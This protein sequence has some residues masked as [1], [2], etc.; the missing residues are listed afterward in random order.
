[1]PYA[2]FY[3]PYCGKSERRSS[4]LVQLVAC[5]A[6]STTIS[7]YSSCYKFEENNYKCL[8]CVSCGLSGIKEEEKLKKKLK[9]SE[10]EKQ[11]NERLLSHCAQCRKKSTLYH[12]IFDRR[13]KKLTQSTSNATDANNQI[14]FCTKEHCFQFFREA[15]QNKKKKEQ[16]RLGKKKAKEQALRR[17]FLLKLVEAISKGYDVSE[18]IS[19]GEWD[20]EEL[21]ILLAALEAKKEEINQ[22]NQSQ[23]NQ[24]ELRKS[25]EE[26][27]ET[28]KQA[29]SEPEPAEDRGDD[30]NN[31]PEPGNI[32]S[33]S[34]LP[35]QNNSEGNCTFCKK[36]L[37]STE[38]TLNY[39]I[40]EPNYKFLSETDIDNNSRLSQHSKNFFKVLIKAKQGEDGGIDNLP[41]SSQEKQDLW[42]I[43]NEAKNKPKKK[44]TFKCHDCGKT[45]EDDYKWSYCHHCLSR[46]IEVFQNG[47]KDH[48]GGTLGY[49]SLPI[50][51]YEEIKGH[52]QIKKELSQREQGFLYFRL[53]GSG[54]RYI[55]FSDYYYTKKVE[56]RKGTWQNIIGKAV[57]NLIVGKF[58]EHYYLYDY[59]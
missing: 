53:I 14:V 40:E 32:P 37:S 41:I 2:I 47:V 46:N 28:Q 26:L 21:E 36:A 3:C 39:L 10:Q 30:D 25:E 22:N 20:E 8:L 9:K 58:G 24:E 11:T 51:N 42:D 57:P 55:D 7:P 59:Q 12:Y 52:R 16:A 50:G 38:K 13:T 27:K 17:E 23:D 1:M 33:S 44:Y 45:H 56:N 34:G 4:D 31:R 49:S 48:H 54:N 29:Q 35:T 6:C 18:Y 15:A 43:Y 5:Q 19:S